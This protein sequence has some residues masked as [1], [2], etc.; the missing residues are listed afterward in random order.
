M[1]L[2]FLSAFYYLV[3]VADAAAVHQRHCAPIYK[4]CFEFIFLNIWNTRA[5]RNLLI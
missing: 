1:F 5:Y 2:A 4:P 3:N